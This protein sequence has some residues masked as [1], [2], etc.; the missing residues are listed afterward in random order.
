MN[1]QT[2]SST[3]RPTVS[4]PWFAQDD[5]LALSQ[6]TR[7]PLA[8]GRLVNDAAEILEQAVVLV[9]GASVLG[10]RIEQASSEDQLF[11]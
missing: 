5:G 1:H 10:D 11:P 2:A 6:F 4:R 8:F 7:D 3:V 9:K